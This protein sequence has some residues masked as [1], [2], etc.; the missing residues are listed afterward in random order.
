MKY[1]ISSTS[2]GFRAFS[3]TLF[4]ILPLINVFVLQ[5]GE[6]I[7]KIELK[8]TTAGLDICYGEKVIAEFSH[9][10]TP[11]GRPFICNIHTLD[12]IK[13]TRNYPITDKDQNDHPHHQGLFHTFSQ[14]NGIDFWHMKGMAKHRLF[15]VPPKDGN[16]ASFSA[17]SVYLDRD[18]ETPLLKETMSYGFHITSEGLLITINAIIE[19]EAEK[20]IIGSKEEGGIAIRVASDLRVQKGGKMI[21]N[22]GRKGGKA[23]WGKAARWVDNSGKKKGRWVG[24]TLFASHSDLGVFHWHSRDYGLIAANPFGPLNKAPDRI[25]KKG[26]KLSFNYG[27]MVHSHEQASEY[28]PKKAEGIYIKNLKSFSGNLDSSL[29]IDG[30]PFFQ[31]WDE[32]VLT[33]QVAVPMDGSVLIFKNKSSKTDEE[34]YISV[35]RSVDGGQT[36]AEEKKVG[37]MVKVDGDMSDDGRY[38]N[39]NWA[40]LGNVVVDEI[41]GDIMV[42]LTTLKTAQKL[43]RSEDH[44]KTWK[45]EETTI[46]PGKDGWMPATNGACDPGVTIKHGSKKGRLLMPARVF[47][48]YLNKGKGRKRYNDLYA[49]ALYSDDRG[50]TWNS[51]A[52]FPIA[53]TGESGLVELTSGRIYHNSR[54]HMRPGNRRI[55]FSDDAGETWY[56]EHEDDELFDGPPDVYGCKA[57]LLRL[58]YENKDILLFSSPGNRETRTDINVWASFDGGQTWPVNKLIKSGPGNYTWMAAGRKGT[59]SEG[60]VYLL[61]GKDWMAR[62]NMAW[63]LKK[64]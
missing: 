22:K 35:K 32:E 18:G 63:L 47:P 29:R 46:R 31:V 41:T 59:P 62:F 19:S 2:V 43:Y 14:L 10:Q 48:E 33:G 20:V 37:D 15:T 55:A 50:K 25:L 26:E 24:A 1:Q 21:D 61:A 27:L 23:I 51:S 11:Q 53:G 13:V 49:M 9:T 52:P 30:E 58:P 8:K 34:K 5:A 28:S 45:I 42:F 12:G 57:A 64:A 7:K 16:P 60:M 39:N 38:P 3:K 17:E 6:N 36:W 44:G 54:T 4:L 56:G 40:G